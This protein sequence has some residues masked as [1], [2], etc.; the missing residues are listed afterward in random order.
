MRNI[1]FKPNAWDKIRT[2][3]AENKLKAALEAEIQQKMVIETINV[4]SREKMA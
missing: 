2:Y 4:S 1:M 3:V